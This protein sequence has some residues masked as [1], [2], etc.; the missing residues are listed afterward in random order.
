MGTIS[1]MSIRLT[2]TTTII[3]SKVKPPGLRMAETSQNRI[4][5]FRFSI[6]AAVQIENRKA[7]F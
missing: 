5:D 7:K 6:A 2:V 1:S 4:F 3:S